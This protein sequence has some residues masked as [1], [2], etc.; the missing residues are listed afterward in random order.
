V[1]N[2][3]GTFGGG[4]Q[5]APT[6]T[7]EDRDNLLAQLQE[8]TQARA[9]ETLQ[10][11]LEPG[12]WLPPETV[13]SFVIAQA[14]SAFNDEETPELGLT[15]R[16]LLQGVA[17]NEA[18]T[19]EAMLAALQGVIPE[20]GML[21]ADTFHMERVPGATALDRAVQFTVTVGGDYIV[22]IDPA[23]VR[24]TIAGLTPEAA[25]EVLGARWNMNRPPEIYLD[26]EWSG[27]LPRLSQRIQV[28]VDYGGATVAP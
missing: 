1:V 7:Q 13:K 19:R 20:R 3:N 15:L 24:S 6:V 27:T 10:S 28:R 26:P 12:E 2:P 8:Q 17:V 18:T 4:S 21:V 9:L 23:E 16:T 14:F 22:P 25:A 5:L 11:K